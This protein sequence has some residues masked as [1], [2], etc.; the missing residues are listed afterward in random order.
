VVSAISLT[1]YYKVDVIKLFVFEKH[2]G[3]SN[4]SLTVI[5]PYVADYLRT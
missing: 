5:K 1:K 4:R 3:M 2:F